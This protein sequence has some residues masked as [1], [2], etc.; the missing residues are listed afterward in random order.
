MTYRPVIRSQADLEA[1]WRSLMEPLGFGAESLWFMLVQADGVAVP[2]VTQI[3]EAT[4]PPDDDEALSVA[5]FLT[6]MADDLDLPGARVAFLRS[7]PGAGG[8][9]A[10]DRAW[11]RSLGRACRLVGMPC[12]VMHV[13][14]DRD[15]F[16]LAGDDLVPA[17]T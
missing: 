10:R 17:A 11:A 7:R 14:T 3:E 13:A 1:A 2:S 6:A 9:D 5:M 8:P 16:P 4:D 15:I 12:E